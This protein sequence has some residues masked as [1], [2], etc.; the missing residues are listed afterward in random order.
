MHKL[1][2]DIPHIARPA[3]SAEHRRDLWLDLG[4]GGGLRLHSKIYVR[5]AT[6]I[7]IQY[8]HKRW[9]NRIPN[10]KNFSSIMSLNILYFFVFY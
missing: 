2:A 6:V 5:F 8:L 4:P 1:C 3:V 10:R 9:S 7:Y